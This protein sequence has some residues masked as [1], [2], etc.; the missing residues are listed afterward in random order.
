MLP[1]TAQTLS[2]WKSEGSCADLVPS[3]CSGYGSPRCSGRYA[4][5]F[6]DSHLAVLL[7][8]CITGMQIISEAISTVPNTA[9]KRVSKAKLLKIPRVTKFY[10]YS[11]LQASEQS[12]GAAYAC[13]QTSTCCCGSAPSC[14]QGRRCGAILNLFP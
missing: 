4:V 1:C 6:R 14:S 10:L 2:I 5:C 8:V 3:G 9:K 11:S 7:I 13:I 12:S